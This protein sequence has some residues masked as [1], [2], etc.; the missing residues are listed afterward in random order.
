MT[1]MDKLLALLK[2]SGSIKRGE[3]TLSSGKKSSIYI[4]I[5][6]AVTHPEVL[7]EIASRMAEKLQALEFDKIACIELGGVPVAVALALK[8]K[9]PIVIFRKSKKDYGVQEDRIGRIKKGE[10]IVVVE[11]VITT[12]K[13]AGNVI[14]RVEKSGGKVVAVIAVVDREESDLNPVSLLRLSEIIKNG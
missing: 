3:F 4:D 9:K 2:N 11:D 13:S 1:S 6:Q 8:M 12:G 7:D 10:R 5:K 14:E